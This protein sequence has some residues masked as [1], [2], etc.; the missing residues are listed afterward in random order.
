MHLDPRPSVAGAQDRRLVQQ[1]LQIG[2]GQAGGL[3]DDGFKIDAFSER[4]ATRVQRQDVASSRRVRRVQPDLA[5]EAARTEQCRVEH[6]RA[7]GGRHHDHPR[8][9]IEAVHLHQELIQRLLALLVGVPARATPS[10]A[11]RVPTM[12]ARCWRPVV[13]SRAYGG[14]EGTG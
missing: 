2:A 8:A 10:T 7:V 5:V 12:K 6:V 1:V 9:E 11:D 4:L 13:S 3:G 14:D